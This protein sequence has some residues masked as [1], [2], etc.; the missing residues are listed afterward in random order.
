MSFWAI[1]V[2]FKFDLKTYLIGLEPHHVKLILN[3]QCYSL[4]VWFFDTLQI[5]YILNILA[6]CITELVIWSCVC[7][8]IHWRFSEWHNVWHDAWR[9]MM[10]HGTQYYTIRVTVS[11]AAIPLLG[12]FN[13]KMPCIFFFIWGKHQLVYYHEHIYIF[14]SVQV[15]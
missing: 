2:T 14:G 9:C 4:A 10:P 7:E 13:L 15:F 12:K 11:S 8:Y 3:G 5:A 6:D 1:L